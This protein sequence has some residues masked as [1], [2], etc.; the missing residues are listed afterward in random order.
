[1]KKVYSPAPEFESQ[2]PDEILLEIDGL[3][4]DGN[5]RF[6]LKGV[7]RLNIDFPAIADILVNSGF[8]L[9]EAES[10]IEEFA[11]KLQA[12]SI[13]NAIAKRARVY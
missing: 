6:I 1:M 9:R 2:M 5:G 12:K 8:E 11:V 10:E 4:P 13:A 7:K 3:I